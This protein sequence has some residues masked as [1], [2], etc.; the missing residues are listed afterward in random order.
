MQIRAAVSTQFYKVVAKQKA[1][2]SNQMTKL[3]QDGPLW[4]TLP[5][6]TP[7]TESIAFSFSK[8]IK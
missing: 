3:G 7:L 4:Q 6:L 5:L 8:A 2:P 1:V